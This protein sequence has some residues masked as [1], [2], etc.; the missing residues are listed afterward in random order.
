VGYELNGSII[1]LETITPFIEKGKTY[2]HTFSVGANMFNTGDYKVKV[3]IHKNNDPVSKNDTLVKTF[4][5]LPNEPISLPFLDDMEYLPV[6]TVVANQTGLQGDGRYDF[7]SNTDAGRIRTFVNTNFAYSGQRALTLDANRY[8]SGG[9]ANF[10]DATFN[11]SNYN[12]DDSDI[13]LNFSYKNHGQKSNAN[14]KVWIR[15]KDT[16]PWIEAYDLFA[17]QKIAQEGYKT[18]P[19]IEI[20]SLLSVNNKNF[21]SSFQVRI[22]QWGRMI[23]ADYT[24]GAGYSFDDIKIFTVTDD[25]QMLSLVQPTAANCGLGSSESVIVQIRNSSARDI[26]NVPVNYRLGNGAVVQDTIPAI[27]KRTTISYTFVDKADLSTLGAQQIKVWVALETDSY[28][29]NDS[30]YLELYNAP[31]ISSFPYIENF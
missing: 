17:N 21:S 31:V 30:I 2:D 6:Q 28:R 25:I 23:T 4:R 18:P 22:G 10:L 9:N 24:T 27:S 12:I 11:L 8:F 1:P 16:D 26:T 13:R 19:G 15:G 20:S 7:S 14:N 29:D 5:Q 3:Y